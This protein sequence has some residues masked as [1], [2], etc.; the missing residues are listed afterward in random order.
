M[1]GFP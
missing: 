1:W